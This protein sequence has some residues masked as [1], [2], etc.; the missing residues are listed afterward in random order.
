MA[1]AL[2]GRVSHATNA[3]RSSAAA[4]FSASRTKTRAP[5]RSLRRAG[6]VERRVPVQTRRL[7]SNARSSWARAR[8]C[9]IARA[10]C[11]GGASARCASLPSDR[12]PARSPVAGRSTTTTELPRK[13]PRQTATGPCARAR[14]AH[15]RSRSMSRPPL[16]AGC[17]PVR[18]DGGSGSRCPGRIGRDGLLLTSKVTGAHARDDVAPG[19]L[20]EAGR[21]AARRL[22]RSQ[23]AL[24]SARPNAAS[25]LASGWGGAVRRRARIDAPDQRA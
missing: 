22:E 19:R 17:L 14:E 4:S 15:V 8:H 6:S 9:Y 2:V 25:A 12:A 20:N 3:A 21:A 13:W 23:A 16:S 5:G 18:S 1:R 24:K 10:P 7:R 11:N